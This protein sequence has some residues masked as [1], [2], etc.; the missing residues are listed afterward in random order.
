MLLS[1]FSLYS[2]S[3]LQSQKCFAP[4]VCCRYQDQYPSQNQ[5][6]NDVRPTPRPPVT[7]G[8]VLTS[9]E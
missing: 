6:T 5:V 2:L 8:E 9:G 1:S 4:E 3:Y 7:P